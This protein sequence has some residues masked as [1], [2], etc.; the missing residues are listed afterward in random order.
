VDIKPY[1]GQARGLK[2]KAKK[3]ADDSVAV[4]FMW[5]NRGDGIWYWDGAGHEIGST[6]TFLDIQNRAFSMWEPYQLFYSRMLESAGHQPL[7]TG[8]P[9]EL[10]PLAPVQVLKP[11]DPAIVLGDGWKLDGN[12]YR[13]TGADDSPLIVKVPK[14]GEFDLFAIV[15]AKN[16]ATLAAFAPATKKPSVGNDYVGLAGGDGNHTAKLRL[17]GRGVNGEAAPLTPGTHRLQLSRR[18]GSIWLIVDG[19]TVAWAPDPNPKVTIDR[20]AIMGG[21]G[22]EQVVHEIRIKT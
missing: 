2:W 17:F 18:D 16:D 6:F 14:I 5:P 7:P 8:A 10:A 3:L 19:K 11:G 1:M 22:G 13:S 20:L 12:V 9:T 4:E 15:E 21:F